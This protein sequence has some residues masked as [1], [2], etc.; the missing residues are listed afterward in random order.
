M[1]TITA[2]SRETPYTPVTPTTDFPCDFPIFGKNV[3][4]FPATDLEVEINGQTRT[5]FTVIATFVDGIST[6]AVVRM[7]V[8]VIGDVV[9]RG[10]RT[11][12]RTDQYANGAP[13]PIS[14]HNYALNRLESEM[15]EVRR[16]TDRTTGGLAQE[17]KDRI[18][19]DELERAERIAADEQEKSQRIASDEAETAARISGDVAERDARIAGDQRLQA[20]VDIINVELDQF[21]SKVARAEAAATSAENSAQEAHEL[22]QQATAGF[23]G[24]EDGLGYDFGFITQTLTYFDRDFG[25]IADPVVN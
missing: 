6:D 9:V 15:Q 16:D 20:Q 12:R 22:V 18:A 1:V 8:G 17:V 21:D 14:A 5:D 3:G 2:S 23:V 10:K 24:F 7:A 11:P 4:E 25:S 13:L 19:A